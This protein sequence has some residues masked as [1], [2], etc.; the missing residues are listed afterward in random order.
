MGK[1]PSL[2]HQLLSALREQ[3]RFGESKH[4]AKKIA[5]AQAHSKGQSGFGATPEGIY[6]I[7]TFASYRQVAREFADWCRCNT[8]AR[9][10]VEAKFYTGFYLQDRIDCGLSAWTIQRDR[11][12]LRKIYKDPELA[13]E[14][15]IPRRRLSDIK[16]SRYV[17]KMDKYFNPADHPEL[18]DFC[19][20]TG[21]R[22]HELKAI[23]P[24]DIYWR[25][26]KLIALVRQ[27]KGGKRREVTVLPGMESR[28]LQIIIGKIPDKPI[29]E[30][31]PQK[32]DVHSFRAGYATARLIDAPEKEVTKDLGHNRTDVIK[33][34]YAWKQK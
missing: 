4:Q 12:A 27:G 15:E 9:T 14:I 5:I 23:C 18:V 34:H 7:G 20:A 26:G 28:V 31:I 17:T 25:G 19:K 2:F 24:K 22:R 6:A 10:M 21:L 30:N 29:F 16:R 8:Q 1:K 33:N 11:S 13:W 3:Q 32:M